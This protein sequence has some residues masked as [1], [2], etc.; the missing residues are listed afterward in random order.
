MPVLQAGQRRGLEP[1]MRSKALSQLAS[2]SLGTTGL[3]P[4]RSRQ[5]ARS[6]CRGARLGGSYAGEPPPRREITVPHRSLPGSGFGS[7][8]TCTRRIRAVAMAAGS[9]V[10]SS[11]RRTNGGVIRA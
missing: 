11:V 4:R 1:K 5:R 3:A 7:T 6:P 9:Q 8:R 10:K 2:L